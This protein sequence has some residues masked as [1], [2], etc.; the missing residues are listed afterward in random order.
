MTPS[1]Q[2]QNTINVISA[3]I[4]QAR[5]KAEKNTIADWRPCTAVGGI[6]CWNVAML[7][8]GDQWIST[9]AKKGHGDMNS[10]CAVEGHSRM[11]I[12]LPRY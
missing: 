11:A 1:C 2:C 6:T 7:L 9:V 5:Q 4:F 3:A 10:W 12:F 8:D